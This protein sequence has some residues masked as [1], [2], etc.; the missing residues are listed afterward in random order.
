MSLRKRAY[1]VTVLFVALGLVLSAYIIR[2]NDADL[3][4]RRDLETVFAIRLKVGDLRTVGF[5]YALYR[6]ERPRLQA[7]VVLRALHPLFERLRGS[8]AFQPA[9]AAVLWQ[10]AFG[11][12]ADCEA[13]LSLF[14]RQVLNP[15]QQERERQMT[16]LFLL[17]GAAL[18]ASVEG[19]SRPLLAEQDAVRWLNRW[20]LGA[21]ILL[22]LGL[23]VLTIALLRRAVLRPL[24]T[25]TE[26]VRSV[27]GGDHALRL[28]SGESGEFG[29]LARAFD[30]ML[31]RIQEVTE[32]LVGA[33]DAAEAANRAKSDFLA[34]MSHEI[35]TPMNGIL[36]LT[37]LLERSALDADQ[38]DYV[39]KT[40]V[41]AQSLLGILNDI[42]DLSKVEAGRMELVDEPF[43]LD[44]LIKTL[45]TIAAGNA[46]DRDIEVLFEIAP[47]TPLTLVGDALRLQ[48]VLVNLASNAIKFTE[49]GEV[50]LSVAVAA[51]D[52]EGVDLLFSVRDTG[53]GIAPETQQAIFEAF[54][55]AD[56]SPGGT[57]F[58]SS[59]S[60][61]KV[62]VNWVT[63]PP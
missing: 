20:V 58:T 63:V 57:H 42:L 2:A 6:E 32:T 31:D 18:A 16:S 21:A 50:V 47:G 19:L 60:F 33:R 14:A 46:R 4:V 54:S 51:E 38:K 56:R 29:A 1:V 48:Q 45:A 35:R 52:A 10:D 62:C 59:E 22:L 25:L 43:R 26:A 39:E 30:Q 5:E 13:L 37:Y 34:N 55:Q 49:R 23:P 36:G 15:L 3:Q 41:S 9:V 11:R 7:E 27:G 44:D 61:F 8:P 24:A 53:I 28:R 17:R 40:R 12:L